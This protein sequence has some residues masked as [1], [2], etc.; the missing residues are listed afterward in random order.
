[1]NTLFTFKTKLLL[2]FAIILFSLFGLKAHSNPI[3]RLDTAVTKTDTTV[4]NSGKLKSDTTLYIRTGSTIIVKADTTMVINTDNKGD[5]ALFNSTSN[6]AVPA[7]GT[8]AGAV[9]GVAG[10]APIPAAAINADGSIKAGSTTSPTAGQAKA[11]AAA[12][13]AGTASA[14]KDSSIAAKT[15]SALVKKDSSITAK[16]DTATTDTITNT[17][18]K[19]IKVAFLEVGG[20]GLA[21]SANFDSRFAQK[22]NGLGYRVGVGYFGSGGNTVVSVPIQVNYLYGQGDHLL[23][24]GAGTTFLHSTGDTKGTYW[25]FDNVTGFIGTATIGYRY[26]PVDSHLNLRI[27]FVPILYDEGIIAAGGISVGY[28]F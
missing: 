2:P 26:Q 16:T 3:F 13:V 20:P 6:G 4:K 28:S 23:E 5:K 1:M 12:T 9:P 24:L 8:A 11:G 17:D 15:D 10:A 18:N 25:Q 21:I 19:R 14:K 27:A 7:N 22:H